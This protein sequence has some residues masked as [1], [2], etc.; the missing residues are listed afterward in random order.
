MHGIK[1]KQILAIGNITNTTNEDIDIELLARKLTREIA[2]SKK[3]VLTNAI[4]GSGAKA[5]TMLRDTRNLDERF[6]PYTTQENGTLDAPRYSLSGKLI[7]RTKPIDSVLRVDYTLLLT[8]TDLHNGRVVWDN[9]ESISKVLSKEIAQKFM[10]TSK[11]NTESTIE[12]DLKPTLE[13]IEQACNNKHFDT[14]AQMAEELCS[15]QNLPACTWAGIAYLG[16]QNFDKALKYSS[17]VCKD[18]A[19]Y[20]ES[21]LAEF[22]GT[23][24]ALIGFLYH[25][26]QGAKQ[27][28]TKSE[29]Y[30]KGAC[31]KDKQFCP[32]AEAMFAAACEDG[33]QKMCVAAGDINSSLFYNIKDYA[34]AKEY[35]SKV[36]DEKAMSKKQLN[37]VEAEACDSLGVMHDRGQD[38][39]RAFELYTKACDSNWSNACVNLGATYRYGNDPIQKNLMHAK[40]YYRKACDLGNE[41]GCYAYEELNQAGH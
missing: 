4:A 21:E 29:S 26:G 32:I 22:E 10:T 16:L 25:T 8:L 13:Q 15:V 36:C 19:A 18:V 41:F 34:K 31:K 5:D 37:K 1:D 28:L 17:L 14:C 30:L 35:Y 40:K 20:P 7:A 6:N 12:P 27:D 24:C 39:I 33:N 38:P 11:T 9:E 2:K 3:F 23:S